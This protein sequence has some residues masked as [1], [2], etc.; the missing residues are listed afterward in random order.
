[1]LVPDINHGRWL[2]LVLGDGDNRFLV[3]GHLFIHTFGGIGRHFNRREDFLDF[4]FYLIYIHV[5]YHYDTLLVGTI[6]FFIIVAE[7]LIR[8]VVNHFDGTDR[9]TMAILASFESF[10]ESLF[11]HTHHGTLSGTPFF[12]DD[13]AFVVYFLRV[14]GQVIGPIVKDEE[15]R[16]HDTVTDN[17][18]VGNVIN[19][20][21]DAGIGIQVFTEAYTN[22]FQIVNQSLTGEVG[23]TVEAHVFQ[24][25]SQASLVFFFEDGTYLLCDVEI[26]T[27]FWQFI[28][29]DV[30]CQ[31]VFQFTDA[32]LGV[33]R[34]R[35]HLRLLLG[36]CQYSAT[37][38]EKGCEEFF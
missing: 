9:Q 5:T 35:G 11:V 18:Y 8:E 13:T 1:M 23:G 26:G 22:R 31:S 30:V 25:V 10:R 38:Y 28:V 37:Q 14:E 24:E 3:V 33:C 34:D 6:P 12:V 4:G 16:I 32:N 17:W 36:R 29:T 15:T 20:F 21:I 19:G 2:F 7:S 27:V